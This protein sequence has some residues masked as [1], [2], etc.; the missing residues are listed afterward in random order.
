MN[1][2]GAKCVLLLV[3]PGIVAR[4]AR[5]GDKRDFFFAVWDSSFSKG[6]RGKCNLRAF[7]FYVGTSIQRRVGAN[8][9][10]WGGGR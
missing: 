2:A 3:L 8:L 1:F 10:V 7:F 6:T 5:P 9:E 4:P